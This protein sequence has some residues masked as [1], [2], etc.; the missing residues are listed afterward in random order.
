M[1]INAGFNNVFGI[2]NNVPVQLC[3][4]AI[5]TA[6]ATLSVMMGLDKG[7]NLKRYQYCADCVAAWFYVIFGP[8][9]FIIDSFIENIGNYVSQPVFR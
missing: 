8:T 1:Q 9:Q 7:L 2:P 5:I 3:L 6:M 4:I